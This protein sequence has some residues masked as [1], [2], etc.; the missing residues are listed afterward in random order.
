MKV[1]PL[2]SRLHELETDLA[3]ELR[4]L[5]E[6]HAAD[7]DVYHQCHTFAMQCDR[8]AR[9]LEPHAA[10]YGE[11]VDD[12]TGTELWSGLLERARHKGAELLGRAPQGGLLL[13]RDLRVLFLAAEE[14]SITWVMAGQAA[15]AAR[16][17]ELLE[18]V[19]TCHT[20]TELQV[21]WLT[22]RIK[23]AAPQAL[24]TG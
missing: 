9:S 13:L 21:K 19:T 8:H 5:G 4:A 12:H 7:H 16:D 3:D 20:E 24:V 10:R 18:T 2:L 17:V 1:G 15:Q 6:R 23:V 22:T 14:A 11:G